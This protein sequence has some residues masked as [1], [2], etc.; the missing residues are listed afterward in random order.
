M[1]KV[2]N[3]VV[4]LAMIWVLFSGLWE[5]FTAGNLSNSE[6]QGMQFF[7]G[8][9]HLATGLGLLAIFLLVRRK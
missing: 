7:G 8:F 2:L 9:D 5:I 1:S 4:I 6:T 3:V